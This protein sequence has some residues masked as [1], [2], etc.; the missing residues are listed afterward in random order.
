MPAS[1]LDYF[2][3]YGMY[4]I[5][6]EIPFVLVCPKLLEEDPINTV[7]LYLCLVPDNFITYCTNVEPDIIRYL[8]KKSGCLYVAC[9]CFLFRHNK[10]LLFVPNSYQRVKASKYV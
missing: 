5:N 10:V 6:G 8:Q 2:I 4:F 3:C 7:T 9:M 1:V